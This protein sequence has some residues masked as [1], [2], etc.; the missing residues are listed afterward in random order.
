[1]QLLSKNTTKHLRNFAIVLA[2][3]TAIAIAIVASAVYSG[4]SPVQKQVFFTNIKC[5]IVFRGDQA[6]IDSIEVDDEYL[7]YYISYN[8]QLKWGHFDNYR[9]HPEES[10]ALMFL[11]LFIM[12]AQGQRNGESLIK[13]LTKEN[14]G[15]KK[16]ERTKNDLLITEISPY[17]LEYFDKNTSL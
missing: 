14:L 13:M 5:P 4:L 2:G 17:L 3:V 10:K 11:S 8:N 12:N 7:T 6:Q 15:I 1:M 16:V 9:N